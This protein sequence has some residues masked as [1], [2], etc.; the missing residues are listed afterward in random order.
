MRAACLLI[1]LALAAPAR[2]ELIDRI[3]AVVAGQPVTLSDVS[4]VLQFRLIQPPAG[5]RDPLAF[6]LD[7]SIERLLMLTEVDRFQPPEPDPVM[8]TIRID[9]LERNAGSA[10][11]FEKVLAVT[12]TTR[13]QLRRYIRDDLRI[14]TYLNQRFGANAPPAERAAAIA[15]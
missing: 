4:A 3:M 9:E 13:E 10:E 15:S 12:G 2:A 6:V 7:R 1:A 5:T 14:T 11:A 8:M